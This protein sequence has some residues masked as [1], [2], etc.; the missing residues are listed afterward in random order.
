[1][2]DKRR[3][4][5]LP[6]ALLDRLGLVPARAPVAYV[7]ERANW[8]TRWDGR[9]I[10]AA[11]EKI[12]PGTA[13]VVDRPHLLAR[14]LV[15]FGSQF[16]WLAWK[17]ALPRSNRFVATYFHGKPE[18]DD[19]MARHVDAFLASVPK[20]ERVVT[21]ATLVERR[22][23]SWG[24][25][26]EKLVR[27]PIGVDLDLFRAPR[28]DERR[29]AR[30]RLGFR[31]EQFVI[32]SFQKDGIGWSDG[33]EPKPIKG[34][35]LFVDAVAQVAKG[36]PVAVLLTGPARGFVK[37]GLEKAGIPYVHEFVD[38]YLDLPSRFWA[39]DLYVNPSRE[40]GGPKGVLESMASGVPVVSTEVGMAPDVIR[41]RENGWLVPAGDR[42]GLAQTIAEASGGQGMHPDWIARARA[43]V[44]ACDWAVVGRRHYDE[45]YRPLLQR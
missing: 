20:L 43:A 31:A 3:L 45:V 1:M 23:L 13:E 6:V 28:E 34:P 42:D 12:A 8:S 9:N 27:I 10:C 7:V 18:D 44:A 2:F 30:E 37:R 35:D 15:H 11:I 29:A 39:L 41:H 14:R 24:V 5:V 21:A 22:L 25:P 38:D 36:H 17:D 16:Q 19:E 33:D 4:A 32:G 26:R 40:E